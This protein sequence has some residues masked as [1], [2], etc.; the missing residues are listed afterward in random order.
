MDVRLSTE[1]QALRASAAQLVATLGPGTVRELGDHDRAA[2]L[3]A[4]V[5]SAGWR[6]LR[7]AGQSGRALASTVETALVAEELGRG[8]ADTAFLG[9]VLAAELRR[10]TG[11]PPATGPETVLLTTDLAG[12]ARARRGRAGGVAI[13]ARGSASALLLDPTTHQ[14]GNVAGPGQPAWQL[15]RVRI[16]GPAARADLTRA[17]AVVPDTDARQVDG[18]QRTLSEADLAGWTAVVLALTCAD[19][20]GVM[21][22]AITAATEYARIRRQY[23][24]PVGSF[25]AIQHLLADAFVAAEGSRSIALY[26]AWAADALPADRAG[27]A[28][29]TAKAYCSRAARTVCETAIQVHGGIGNTWECMAHVFLRRALLSTRILGGEAASLARVLAGHGLAGQGLAG[30]G[31]AVPQSR[32]S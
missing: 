15:A 27:T 31:P 9:P 8:L 1:Q 22:G 18:Q 24:A 7:D 19:L 3:D 21:A 23:G 14:D 26:A 20:V 11:A 16:S 28:A 10:L 6:E 4:A 32:P 13:D 17:L 30:H 2:R 5:A 12:L 29:A 25:Q